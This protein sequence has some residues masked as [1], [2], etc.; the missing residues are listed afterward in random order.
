MLILN[1]FCCLGVTV[2]TV[3]KLKA[4]LATV[5]YALWVL[6]ARVQTILRPGREVFLGGSIYI[7]IHIIYT[8]IY[9]Y[10]YIWSPPSPQIYAC[11][12]HH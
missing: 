7:Y 12:L 6:E 5:S 1:S 10:I 2:T 8:C 4:I 11:R 3:T 9:I